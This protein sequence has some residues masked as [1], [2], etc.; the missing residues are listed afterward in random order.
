MN[1]PKKF[2][3]KQDEIIRQ[4]LE[5]YIEIQNPKIES[6]TQARKDFKRKFIPVLRKA[7]KVIANN[8]YGICVNCH[9]EIGIKRLTQ[10]PAAL[11]CTECQTIYEVL[12]DIRRS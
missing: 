10:V 11:R 4:R 8:L 7:R 9:E 1:I 6:E 12:H 2:I 3:Q 5:H